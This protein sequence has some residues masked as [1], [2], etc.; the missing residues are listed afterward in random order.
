[1][2]MFGVDSFSLYFLVHMGY[3]SYDAVQLAVGLSN[4]FI[5]DISAQIRGA[6]KKFP[7][8]WFS[9]VMV[10]HVTTLV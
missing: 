6:V 3:R 5:Y 10:G 4:C 7:E 8:T 1:M 2:Q 9:T